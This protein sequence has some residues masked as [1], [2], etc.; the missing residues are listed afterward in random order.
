MRGEC[1]GCSAVFLLLARSEYLRAPSE[2]LLLGKEDQVDV[3]YFDWESRPAVIVDGGAWFRPLGGGPWKEADAAEVI[4]SGHILLPEAFVELFPAAGLP[5]SMFRH[6]PKAAAP[7]RPPVSVAAT[8]SVTTS[9]QRRAF[10]VVVGVAVAAAVFWFVPDLIG[11]VG[12]KFRDRSALTVFAL[13]AVMA[14]AG[15]QA[16]ARVGWGEWF[17][18]A[19]WPVERSWIAL[20]IAAILLFASVPYR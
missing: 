2:L 9:S 7:P 17:D 5:P 4:D 10:G 15:F 1:S 14:I 16:A 3:Q 20:G 11:L 6:A 8:V 19:T 13:L 18:D 12:G